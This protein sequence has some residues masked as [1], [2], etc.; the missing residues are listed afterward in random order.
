MADNDAGPSKRI[1]YNDP[2]FKTIAQECL[3]GIDDFSDVDSVSENVYEPSDHDTDS[4]QEDDELDMHEK[5]NEE[6]IQDKSENVDVNKILRRF[7]N[8][9][10][11][12][13]HKWSS[14]S[15][16]PCSRTQKHNI[17][18]RVPT[19]KGS[20]VL[21]GQEARS[22]TVW[23]LLV[24]DDILNI[25]L[26]WTNEKIQKQ[27]EKLKDS[28]RAE[29][30]DLDIIEFRAF[31]GLLF[32]T[33]VFVSNHENINKIIATDGTGRM[34]FR[35]VMS[36]QRFTFLLACVRFDNSS[37]RHLRRKE[38]PLAPI[39]EIF[40][41]FVANSQVVYSLGVNCCIDE[42]LVSFRGRCKYKMYMPNKPCKYG[43]K[44]VC[45]TDARTQYF[46]NG[47]I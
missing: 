42:I 26:R 40:N 16:V 14:E 36:K 1:R 38:D 7:Q 5:N 27:R 23:N 32:Y 8:F 46:F 37:D 18:L 24:T 43:I 13:R 10:E 21:L 33:A 39:S 2:D 34:I 4:E 12:D 6:T 28:S 3:D 25:I 19:L 15:F 44:I 11:R 35:C 9:Y 20:S 22:C 17:V 45:M 31:I 47:Y 41:K 30:Q 29:H